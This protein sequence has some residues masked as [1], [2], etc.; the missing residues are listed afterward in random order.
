MSGLA[1][2]D[3]LFAIMRRTQVYEGHDNDLDYDRGLTRIEDLILMLKGNQKKIMFIGNGGSAGI[4]SHMA[5]DYWRNGGIRALCFNDGALLTCI[6]N[7]FGYENVFAKP[8]EMFAE[9]GDILVAISSSGKSEN[10]LNAVRAASDKQCQVITLS[11]FSAQNP[12]RNS[13]DYNIY[14]PSGKYGF[15]ELAHQIILHSI[16]DHITQAKERKSVDE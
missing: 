6:G 11:G 5:L 3:N 12:L 9:P 16:L 15:V 1:Y 8:I 10:I 13:G 2:L 4:A 7:D 14:V